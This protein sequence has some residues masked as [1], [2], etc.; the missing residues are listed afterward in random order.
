[1]ENQNAM[2]KIIWN[3]SYSVGVQ[4]L[5]QQHK[6]LIMMINQVIVSGDD[7]GSSGLMSSLLTQMTRYAE[8]HFQAEEKYMLDFCFPEYGS[9]HREHMA[10]I[11]KTAR[12]I[13]TTISNEESILSDMFTYLNEWLIAHILKSDMQYKAFFQKKGLE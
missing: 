4:E 12:F 10:F 5:D 6:K 11:R 3:E 8:I 2:D 7:S 13:T 9:H 1:M